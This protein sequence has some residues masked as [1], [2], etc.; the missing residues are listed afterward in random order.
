MN[1]LGEVRV[2]VLADGDMIDVRNLR[3]DCIQA[4]FDRQRGKTAE[5]FM[6]VET[7]LGNG[8]FHFAIQNDRR[9]SIGVKHV[10]A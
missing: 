4:C 1:F 5:M 3:A 9:R 2:A 8:K 10:E 6:A 7:L